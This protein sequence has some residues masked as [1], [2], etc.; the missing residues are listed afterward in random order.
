DASAMSIRWAVGRVSPVVATISGV[1]RPIAVPPLTARRRAP[2]RAMAC[3]PL[4]CSAM[5]SV[6][7][8][9]N[10]VASDHMASGPIRAIADA[11]RR[12][13]NQSTTILWRTLMSKLKASA[14]DALRGHLRDEMTI[15]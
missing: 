12:G 4:T 3:A 13:Y 7:I 15:A 10:R 5:R 8:V 1:A 9:G 14:E 2:A 11:H 6:H